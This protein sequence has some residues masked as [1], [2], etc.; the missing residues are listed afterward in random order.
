MLIDRDGKRLELPYEVNLWETT[1]DP[2]APVVDRRAA[3]PGRL[4]IRSADADV[5]DVRT[6]ADI[7]LNYQS[8]RHVAAAACAVGRRGRAGA[9]RAGRGRRPPPKLAVILVVD[10]MR[11]DYVDRFQ[12]DWTGGLKRW[13]TQG[14][15]FQRAAYPYL[16]TVTCAG[17]ATMSTG[18]F[19][20]THGI[21]QN[22]WW[23]RERAQAG[24]LH[25]GSARDRR[26]LRRRRSTGG[27]S[28]HRA[29]GADLRRRDARAAPGPRRLA[30]A[31]GSQR[32]SCSPATAA[33]RSTWLT[34]T[35]DGWETST[36]FTRERRCRG[37][38]VRR[39]QPDR[40][41]T[42]AR[43]GR[44]CCRP[45]RYTGPTTA[46]AKRRRRAGRAAFRTS[47]KGT[48]G[49]AGR[50]VLRAVG[51]QPVCR[52]VRRRGSRRRS[53]SRCSSASTTAPMS[54]PSASRAPTWSAT[55]SARAARKSRTCT[56]TSIGR[57]GTLFDRARRAGRP[58][59]V[60]GRAQRRPRRDADPRTARRRRQ[61]RRADQRGGDRRRG[62]AGAAAGARPRA[63]R[64]RALNTNDLYFEPGVYERLRS[65]AGA[66]ST[67]SIAAIA[68]R[69]ASSAC[70]AAKSSATRRKSKRSAAARRGAQ[71]LPRPQRR[72]DRRAEAGLDDFRRRHDARHR[73]TPTI[74][75]CRSCSWGRHQAGQVSARRRRRP[76]SRRRWR[77]IVGISMPKAEGHRAA[78]CAARRTSRRRPTFSLRVL[79]VVRRI[80][81][82]RVATYGDVAALAGRPRAARAVGNIMRGCGRPDV[83]CH[84]VI[85]AGGR[86][87]GYGGSEMLKRSLLVAEG[88]IV[89]RRAGPR[90]RPG[91]LDARS[92]AAERANP[93]HSGLFFSYLLT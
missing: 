15:W 53:S 40:P 16:T 9:S 41:P 57:I 4:R 13:S 50:D 10:Q 62:R 66:R 84:R 77:R 6:R 82:G 58:G 67:R 34:N 21:F 61:G 22:A 33:T 49:N 44:A 88:V 91:P 92:A 8:D 36:A 75:A 11:A 52:R 85:A 3:R 89:V 73:R 19:P 29:A 24:A 63:V 32:R 37:Q 54:S 65:D 39:R 18:A 7:A 81:P 70:S 68:A 31:E 74:S 17:H 80:P 69:P 43:P 46:S 23:D 20:H 71:L 93:E 30:G 56:R 42:T 83:P 79:S 59:R 90:A 14:A 51:A 35:L 25:R 48:A 45:R 76:I 72:P 47:L 87:G 26:R 1:E 86:L 5:D 27:D 12:G 55:R 78:R 2:A 38:G 28:A 64:R 60:R